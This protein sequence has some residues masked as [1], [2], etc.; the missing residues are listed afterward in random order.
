MANLLQRQALAELAYRLGD[1]TVYGNDDVRDSA[2]AV[3]EAF[4]VPVYDVEDGAE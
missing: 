3:L 4:E 2:L 1:A